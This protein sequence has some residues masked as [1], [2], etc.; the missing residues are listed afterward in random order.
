M[1]K[2]PQVVEDSISNLFKNL[3][4][5]V[6]ERVRAKYEADREEFLEYVRSN[7]PSNS[8]GFWASRSCTKCYG[9]G[10]IGELTRPGGQKAPLVCHCVSKNYQIW[11]TDQRKVFNEKKK[12]TI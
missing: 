11:L 3:P 9:R 12:E 8:P 10:I 7:T 2:N 5:E 4:P 6:A 1:N